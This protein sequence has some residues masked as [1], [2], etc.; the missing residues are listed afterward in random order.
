MYCIALV[1]EGFLFVL[2]IT[3]MRTRTGTCSSYSEFNIFGAL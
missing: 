1:L 2:F 3:R